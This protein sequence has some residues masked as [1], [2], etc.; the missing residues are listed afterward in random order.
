MAD[1]TLIGA[2]LA[3]IALFVGMH[4]VSDDIT[5]RPVQPPLTRNICIENKNIGT[6]SYS[7]D[8]CRITFLFVDHFYRK[9]GYGRK[10]VTAAL[11]DLRTHGCAH[12]S[13]TSS[14]DAAPFYKV[15]GFRKVTTLDRIFSCA[16]RGTNYIKRL[17]PSS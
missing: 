12:V 7:T 8:E 11:D 3:V 14:T 5:T 1:L 9:A 2:L 17:D 13:V 16:P 4:V 10:L 6:I 15:L